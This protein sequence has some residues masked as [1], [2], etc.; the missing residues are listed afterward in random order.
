MSRFQTQQNF[1]KKERGEKSPA[2]SMGVLE[3]DCIQ[4]QLLFELPA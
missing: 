3:F 4:V 1:P 2:F